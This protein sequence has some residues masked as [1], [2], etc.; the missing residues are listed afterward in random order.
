MD[1]KVSH[2]AAELKRL[3]MLSCTGDEAR[4]FLHAQ[5]TSDISGLEPDRARYAG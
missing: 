3:G 2:A 1:T 4:A 5:L